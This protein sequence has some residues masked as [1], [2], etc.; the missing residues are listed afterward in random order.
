MA[1]T[2]PAMTDRSMAVLQLRSPLRPPARLKSRKAN[3]PLP[4][5]LA[6]IL[7]GVSLA[8]FA[9]WILLTGGAPVERADA[10]GPTTAQAIARAGA[11]ELPSNRQLAVEPSGYR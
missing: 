6:S 1:G 2:S 8:I 7:A 11:K 4:R 10:E 3:M 9:G 5:T